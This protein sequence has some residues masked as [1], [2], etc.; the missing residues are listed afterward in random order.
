VLQIASTYEGIRAGE[1]LEKEGITCNLTLLFSLVQAAA[2]A[3][4]GITLISPFVGRIMD[5]FKA[6]TGKTYSGPEDPGVLSVQTIYGYF[7]K[8]G[9]K[10]IVMGERVGGHQCCVYVIALAAAPI[11]V[12]YSD[13][14]LFFVLHS[15]PPPPPSFFFVGASFRNKD[16][17]LSLAGCDK[18][19]IA[20][21]LLE[22]LRSTSGSTVDRVLDP[23]RASELYPGEKIGVG[24][25][26][27]R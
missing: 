5:W 21:S 23:A 18:L 12:F 24:E 6:K 17:I 2:C 14:L 27:F 13:P 7:K 9:Y 16:E 15:P 11:I 3:E 22:E 10:T 20:P 1:I 25:A 26:A 4:A 19:T 8:F